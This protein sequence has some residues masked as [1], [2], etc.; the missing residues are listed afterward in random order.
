MKICKAGIGV[1]VL[2]LL[3]GE[4]GQA[5]GPQH[6][7][8]G[9]G[10]MRQP[11][12]APRRVVRQLPPR[13]HRVVVAGVPYWIDAGIYYRLEN[14]GYIVV[15]AP[16]VRVLP[17]HY[18]V[19][20][21]GGIAYYVADGVYYRSSAGGYI[22]VEKPIE[23]V[24]VVSKRVEAPV[25]ASDTLTLYVPKRTGDEF[26]TVT[27]KKLDGGYLG[28]QGEFY[29]TMP[30][31]ALLTE[32]YGVP[33]ELRQ[34]RSDVYFI[35]VP[36]KDGESF[37]RVTLTRHNGGYLGPQGEFYPLMP[38]VAHLA[39]MYGSGQAAPEPENSDEAE[40]RIK[41]LRKSGEGSVE[42]ILRRHEQG[43]LGPQ[44]EFYPELPSAEQLREMYDQN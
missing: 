33:E 9:S 4:V 44:G 17:R 29:P 26:V 40:V 8:P 11:G 15:S 42:V 21:I 32:M 20:V 22:I 18:R 7:G 5:A 10:P 19:V 31:V 6:R 25:T 35:H 41:V 34:V 38:T 13:A 23:T 43:Y 27:L 12:P 14:D 16:V 2:M 24:E 37:T 3:W 28:P 36:N 1:L 39:E 30:P